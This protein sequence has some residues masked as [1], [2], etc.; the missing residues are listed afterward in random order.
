M[1]SRPHDRQGP[2]KSSTPA[3]PYCPQT[4]QCQPRARPADQPLPRPSVR[5]PALQRDHTPAAQRRKQRPQPVP[6]AR[7]AWAGP[8][9][10]LGDR[11]PMGERYPLQHGSGSVGRT[12]SLS[13]FTELVHQVPIELSKE[14]ASRNLRNLHDASH[15]GI[16]SFRITESRRGGHDSGGS[17]NKTRLLSS[18]PT[19]TFK[20]GGFPRRMAHRPPMRCWDA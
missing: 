7:P 5:A 1:P 17:L 14:F 15:V 10:V 16:P 2:R 3:I 9:S 6:D 18:Q 19:R 8:G 20:L 12:S 11:Q 13:V 4:V